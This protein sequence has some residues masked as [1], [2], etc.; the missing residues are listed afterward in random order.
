MKDTNLVPV[1]LCGGQGSRLWPLSRNN[2]PKQFLKLNTKS[3]KSLLQQTQQ[4]LQNINNLTDPIIICNETHRFIVAEQMREINIKPNSIILETVMKNTAPAI[5]LA[6]LKSLETKND[7]ILIVVASDHL[8]KD[9]QSF[10]KSLNSAIS[11][12]KKNKIITFGIKPTSAETGYG[13]IQ[14]AENLD[15][16]TLEG[17]E[18]KGFIEKPE[19]KIAERYLRDDRYSWNSGMFVFKASVILK[20]LEIYAPEILE[21]CRNALDKFVNDLDFVRLDKEEFSKCPSVSIDVAVMEKTKIGCVVPLNA[22]WSDIGSFKSIWEYEEKNNQG[23]LIQGNVFLKNV[24]NSFFKSED[25]LLVGFGLEDLIAIDTFDVTFIAKKE[26]SQE[27]KKLVEEMKNNCIEEASKNKKGFRPWGNYISIA[28][29]KLWQV[30]ILE[31]NVGASLSL[32]KHNHRSEHWVV[33]QGKALVRIGSIEKIL[34]ENQSVY[35][36]MGVKHRL[37]NNGETILRVIEVQS[38]NYLGEDDIIRYED[39]YSR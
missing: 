6:A 24:K 9:N 16:K 17:S 39:K 15:L 23:N 21:C 5:T 36:P 33:V 18:I 26:L 22:E 13:Y 34:N 10:L 31:V 35:I 27:V 32:Q 1:I 38:G 8:I 28:R 4:R 19:K 30:K 7:P 3:D 37:S 2:Y 20:E 25:R 14:S 11:I 29:D 12:A